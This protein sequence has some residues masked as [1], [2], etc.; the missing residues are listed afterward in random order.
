MPLEGEVQDCYRKAGLIAREAL[1]Y[2][3]GLVKESAKYLKVCEDIEE[4]IRSKGGKP[5]FPVNIAIGSVAAH[6]S[7]T[8]DCGEA[9]ARGNIV[10]LDVGVQVNG[11]IGDTARTLEVG[12]SRQTRLVKASEEALKAA[13]EVIKPK[14]S[15]ETIGTA[16][17]NTIN[18]Y[19]YRPI[20]NLS[21]HGLGQ[22]SLHTGLSIPNVPEGGSER[23]QEGMVLAVEP[24]ATDGTGRVEEAGSGSIYRVIRTAESTISEKPGFISKFLGK[25]NVDE[26][27]KFLDIVR[28]EYRTLPF[29]E[30]WCYAI[31]KKAQQ[32]LQMLSRYK[33]IS[34]YPVLKEAG[35]GMVS[36][37]EHTVLVTADGCE[38]LT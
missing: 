16:V 25:N 11:Y 27:G 36:Q 19:G 13:I 32:K 23:I 35:G 14:V 29:S 22:Y 34:V 28:Y 8:H 12:T 9:F 3:A 15:L 31:D 1:G 17:E 33:V 21:G 26:I 7:P 24:F 18:S 37:C 30:R 6:F 10:K 5:A 38:V 4:Y 20:S 2:G